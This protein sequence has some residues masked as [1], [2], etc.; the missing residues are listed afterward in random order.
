MKYGPSVKSVNTVVGAPLGP[1]H[2]VY[3]FDTIESEG[4]IEYA[5]LLGVFEKESK[6]PVYF[7]ASEVNTLAQ[8]LGGGSHFL[9]VFDGDSHA[10]LGAS[11]DWGD[12]K[13]FFRAAMHLA[14]EHFG[15][16]DEEPEDGSDERA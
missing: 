6:K 14:K 3:L 4:L 10:N 7:V 9:G 8:A 13:K 5:Y 1:D 2:M 12:P 11:D 16:P 15:I